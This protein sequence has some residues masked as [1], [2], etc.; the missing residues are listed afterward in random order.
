MS[1]IILN[2][3]MKL[4]EVDCFSCEIVILLSF[5]AMHH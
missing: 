4:F 1:Y 2:F 5:G 3:L